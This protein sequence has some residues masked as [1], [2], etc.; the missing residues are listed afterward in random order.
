MQKALGLNQ[1]THQYGRRRR[2]AATSV[3]LPSFRQLLEHGLHLGR[4]GF[5]FYSPVMRRPGPFGRFGDAELGWVIFGNLQVPQR[6][7]AG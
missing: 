2:F 5:G 3:A 4:P 6:P 1:D 7:A